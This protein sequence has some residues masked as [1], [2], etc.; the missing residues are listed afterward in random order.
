MNAMTSLIRNPIRIRAATVKWPRV[1]GFVQRNRT[2]VMFLVGLIALDVCV[3]QFA[4]LWQRHSPDDYRGRVEECRS[5]PRDFV[6]LGGSP[7]CEGL[8]PAIVGD[9]TRDGYTLGFPGGTT[10][11]FYYALVHACPTPP[12]VLVYGITASDIN[13]SRGEPHG[14]HSLLTWGDLAEWVQ[15]RPEAGEWAVRHFLRG[16][17]ENASNLFRYRHAIRMWATIE[18]DAALPGSCPQTLSQAVE[19]RDYAAGLVAGNGYSPMKGFQVAPF[20]EFKRIGTKGTRFDSLHYLDKYRTGSHLKYLHKLIDW[21]EA[22]RVSL[23]L[24]DMPVTAALERMYAKE[25][26]EFRERLAV[27][28]RERQVHVLRPTREDVGLTDDQFADLI[29]MNREGG[30]RLSEWL[31]HHMPAQ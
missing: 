7:V 8:D 4:S 17:V 31:R 28:E 22:N 19:Q 26:A 30:K 24:L 2:L 9:G 10:S 11:D 18:T 27:V 16:K 20:S 12:R 6:M 5:R 23:V 3:G 13:D 29:H 14:A 15:V 1:A 21:C 25:F